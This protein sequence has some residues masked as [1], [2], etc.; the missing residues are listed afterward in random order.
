MYAS[1]FL[2]FLQIVAT[3]AIILLSSSGGRNH[4]EAFDDNAYNI[5]RVQRV[6]GATGRHTNRY[7]RN[8]QQQQRQQGNR[9]RRDPRSRQNSGDVQY[10][11]SQRIAN[12]LHSH[13]HNEQHKNQQ[14]NHQHQRQDKNS[15]EQQRQHVET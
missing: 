10:L 14:Q 4:A 8:G 3:V 1:S 6:E 2:S 7:L 12:A 11:S 13:L 5:I 9:D 15:A